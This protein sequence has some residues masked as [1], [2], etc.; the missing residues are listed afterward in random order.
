MQE[1]EVSIDDKMNSFYPDLL[2]SDSTSREIDEPLSTIEEY[3]KTCINLTNNII[4]TQKFIANGLSMEITP[5]N[6][7]KKL[8]VIPLSLVWL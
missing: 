5:L 7:R 3:G 4:P 2:A 8:V 6:E 1:S